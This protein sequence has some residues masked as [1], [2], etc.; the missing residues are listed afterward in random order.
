MSLY[1]SKLANRFNFDLDRFYGIVPS[2]NISAI[3]PIKFVVY[4]YV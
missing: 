4:K 2:E 3:G 1:F